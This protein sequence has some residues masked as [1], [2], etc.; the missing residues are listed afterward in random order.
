MSHRNASLVLLL[1]C[2]GATPALAQE[3]PRGQ[4]FPL[5]P[6]VAPRL[7]P[8]ARVIERYVNPDYAVQRS[9]PAPELPDLLAAAAAL[10]QPSPRPWGEP[11]EFIQGLCYDN[12][13]SSKSWVDLHSYPQELV[14]WG[15]KDC[16]ST[17]I[18]G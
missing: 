4:A 3:T 7:D 13:A 12:S 14:D 2:A 5:P 18:V 9:T 10:E 17:G 1:A 15:I 16:N 8:T 11:E 6:G